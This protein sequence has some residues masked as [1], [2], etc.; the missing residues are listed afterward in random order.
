VSTGKWRNVYAKGNTSRAVSKFCPAPYFYNIYIN[1]AA[2]T[3]GIY[4]TLFVDD[5]CLDATDRKEVSVVRKL[6]LGLSSME[7][8]FEGCNIKINEDKTQGIY[9][10]RSYRPPE[11]HLTLNGRN[12]PFVNSVKYLDAIFDSKVTWSLHIEMIER[13]AFRTLTRIYSLFKSER[14][15]TNIKLTIHKALI[16]SIMTYACPT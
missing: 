14:L 5:T 2:Q 10:P 12:I 8:W 3:P 6:Q 1:D 15:S 9:F 13:K 11:S 16:R 7:T 4:L